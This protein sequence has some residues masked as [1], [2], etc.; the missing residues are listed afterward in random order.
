MISSKKGKGKEKE[1]K[2]RNSRILISLFGI[3]IGIILFVTVCIISIDGFIEDKE[4]I[5]R[6]NAILT[7][8]L[9][10]IIAIIRIKQI[11]MERKDLNHSDVVRDLIKIERQDWRE[12][13]R[14]LIIGKHCS[15]QL[16]LY[17]EPRGENRVQ[18]Y[19]YGLYTDAS[20]RREGY[21]KRMLEKAESIARQE[22]FHS[23]FLEWDI[24]DTPI[25]IFLW[26]ERCGYDEIAMNPGKNSLLRKQL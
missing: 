21:A 13:T 25:D 12:F 7:A 26:Y 10:I 5:N 8:L 3:L 2:K 20:H 14:F 17:K 23:V 24:K 1:M 11:N 15:V 18:A 6:I 9:G 4:T 22:G 19:I 16:E